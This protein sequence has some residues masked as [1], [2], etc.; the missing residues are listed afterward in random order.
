MDNI[1]TYTRT[2][3]APTPSGFLH[4][5]NIMSFAI[6]AALARKAHAKILLRIDDLDR[7]R[8]EPAYVQDIFDSLRYMQITWDEGPRNALEFE[9]SYSQL[10]R[11]DMY[12][13]ALW[14]LE[15][16]GQVFACTCSRADVFRKSPDGIYFGTCRHK[17]IP[18]DTPN[19]SWRLHT[20]PDKELVVKTWEGN[21]IKAILPP[22]MQYFVVRKKDGVPAYQ[23]S[24]LMDDLHFGVDLIVRGQDLWPSTLAQL[25]LASVLN[26]DAFADNVFHHHPLLE[27]S[28]GVKLSKSAGDTS[29]QYLRKQGL[30]PHEIY[31]L[32]G[33]HYCP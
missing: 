9:T 27:A 30:G 6:T 16:G 5:G 29:I 3:I 11:M 23:L 15:Q 33:Q 1:T 10:H 24:S 32:I 12:R 25:F 7:E 2:R 4:L 31:G 28:P 17:H 13:N 22:A 14:Q 26:R 18:L 21:I 20:S 8:V 19:A